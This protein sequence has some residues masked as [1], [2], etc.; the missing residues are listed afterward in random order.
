MN[1]YGS[2]VFR[3]PKE[4]EDAL[5][6]ETPFGDETRSELAREVLQ[7]GD[8]RAIKRAAALLA[9]TINR[10]AVD[11]ACPPYCLETVAECA[12]ALAALGKPSVDYVLWVLDKQ[13]Q[14]GQEAHSR[15]VQLILLDML[16]KLHDSS[17]IP[18]LKSIVQTTTNRDETV[19]RAANA[20]LEYLEALEA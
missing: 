15:H 3:L 11:G 7:T 18:R 10:G 19:E 14:N 2:L 5:S 13:K 4:Q 20:T 16:E 17:A 12:E 8:K 9:I 6:Q 1:N